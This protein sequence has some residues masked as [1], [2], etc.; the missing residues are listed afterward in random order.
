[1]GNGAS[2]SGETVEKAGFII[3]GQGNAG[4]GEHRVLVSSQE[5]RYDDSGKPV[6]VLSKGSTE[7]GEPTIESARRET[8]EETGVNVERLLGSENYKKLCKGE[9]LKFPIDSGKQ[10]SNID[11]KQV[12]GYSGVVVEHASAK[13]F[14]HTYRSRANNERSM[15][16]YEIRVSGIDALAGGATLKNAQNKTREALQQAQA[17]TLPTFKE[18]T[19]WLK[20]GKVKYKGEECELSSHKDG[21]FEAL[22]KQYRIGDNPSRSEWRNFCDRLA[23]EQPKDY[24]RLKDLSKE[25]RAFLQK[26]GLLASDNTPLKLDERNYPLLYYAEGAKVIGVKDFIAGA[27]YNMERLPTYGQAFGGG[28]TELNADKTQALQRPEARI[29]TSQLA[30]VGAFTQPGEFKEALEDAVRRNGGTP[31]TWRDPVL[32]SVK[33]VPKNIPDPRIAA[34]QA[35]VAALESYAADQKYA[36]SLAG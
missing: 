36:H 10:T 35:V 13:P 21:W 29:I 32:Q 3:H 12:Q 18:F 15:A 6:Y 2:K 24:S 9:P 30:A 17:D 31:L 33:S 4:K 14:L 26:K 19:T 34:G 22:Q 8:F 25:I 5:G 27:L 11:G 28:T 1:M 16:L 23:D 7:S 20:N